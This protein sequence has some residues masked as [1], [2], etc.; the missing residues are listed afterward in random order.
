VNASSKQK[1]EASVLIQSGPK[2]L[3]SAPHLIRGGYRFA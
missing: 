1:T 2:V 3:Q